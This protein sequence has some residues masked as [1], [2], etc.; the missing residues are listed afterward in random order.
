MITIKNKIEDCYFLPEDGSIA[1]KRFLE[2]LSSPG[3]LYL[4]CFG[5]TL[6]EAFDAII[7]NDKSGYNQSLLLDYSQASGVYARDKIKNLIANTKNTSII[8]TSAGNN[9]KRPSAFWHWKGLVK[10]PLDRRK[11]PLCMD[12]STNI[13]VSAF[14][15][16]NSM[17]FFNN[18]LWSET[19]V[20][21]HKQNKDWALNNLKHY[22]PSILNDGEKWVD[23]F[24]DNLSDN[25][26]IEL[27]I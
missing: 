4:S 13:S 25:E 3:E 9:S 11:A 15:Q 26:D 14:Y 1:K 5:F 27:L 24:F 8:L 12:G 19:F 20:N 2:T 17:R 10:M 7:L 21:Q 6:Q 23:N 18:S 16:G 22:Q